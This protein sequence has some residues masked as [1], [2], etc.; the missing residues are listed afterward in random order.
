M[1]TTVVKIDIGY[2][3][4]IKGRSIEEFEKSPGFMGKEDI[5]FEDI[6]GPEGILKVPHPGKPFLYPPVGILRA[7]HLKEDNKGIYPL[8]KLYAVDVCL[9]VHHHPGSVV[10]GS[11]VVWHPRDE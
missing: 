10:Q 7:R 6:Q 9:L 2:V 8:V 4:F 5:E 11:G 1:A 3:G